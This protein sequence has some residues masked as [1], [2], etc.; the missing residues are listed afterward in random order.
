M[1]KLVNPEVSSVVVSEKV[2]DATR[3]VGP[4]AVTVT[5]VVASATPMG[6]VMTPVAASI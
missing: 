5:G 3:L 2:L 4:V 6:M 1:P